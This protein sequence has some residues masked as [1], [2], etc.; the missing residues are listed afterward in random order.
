VGVGTTNSD[1]IK[2]VNAIHGTSGGEMPDP[3]HMPSKTKFH[4]DAENNTK[5]VRN[6]KLSKSLESDGKKRGP[7]GIRRSKNYLKPTGHLEYEIK[8]FDGDNSNSFLK[9]LVGFVRS[10]W[11]IIIPAIA[12]AGTKVLIRKFNNVSR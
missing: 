9:T 5:G 1:K 11:K 3:N 10:N 8:N 12:I 4:T 7:N 6:A 2:S